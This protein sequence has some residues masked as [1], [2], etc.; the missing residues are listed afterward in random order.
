MASGLHLLPNDDIS[1]IVVDDAKFTCEMIRRV[2]KGAGFQDIRVA[3]SAQ[4]ALEMMRQRKANILVA[5]WLMPEMD[6]LTLTQ[7]VRQFDEESSHYTYIILLTAKEGADSLAEAFNHGVDDFISKS[8]DSTQL[9]ARINAAGRISKLQSDLIKANERLSAL[10]RHLEE[11]SCFDTVTGLGNRSYLERQIDNTMRHIEARGGGAC[12]VV[13]RINDFELLR[14][15]HGDRVCNEVVEAT[16]VR[17]QQ[18]VRPLDVV[19]RLGAA[20]FALLM[21]QEEAGRTH[22]N[23]FR[24][25]HQALNLRAYK[26]GAGFLTATSAMCIASIEP[27]EERPTPAEIIEFVR[28]HLDEAQQMGRILTVDW[29]SASVR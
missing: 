15:R 22:G 25:V 29:D 12:L 28:G 9:L 13:I 23:S 14:R 10:N 3:N 2:L 11:R 27:S 18:S 24:R 8:P 26:T 20:E 21:Q 7:R 6:G 5:D 1:V 16:A 19:A 17:L 4:Q